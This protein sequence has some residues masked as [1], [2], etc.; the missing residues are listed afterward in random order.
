MDARKLH[1]GDGS[2]ARPVPAAAAPGGGP[3]SRWGD[4]AAVAELLERHGISTRTATRESLSLSLANRTEAVDFL[5]RTA[6]HVVSEQPRLQHEGRWEQLRDDLAELVAARDEGN[7]G[8]ELR[9]E[10]LVVV[11]DR[12]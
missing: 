9:C 12:A 8:V 1:A 3:P 5:I 7:D 4:E 10:Y 6:G 2:G 11:A